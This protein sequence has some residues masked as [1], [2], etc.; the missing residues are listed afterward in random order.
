[1]KF[2]HTIKKSIYDVDFYNTAKMERNGVAMKYYTLF[3]MLMVCITMIPLALNFRVSLHSY[4]QGIDNIRS[5]IVDIYPDELVLNFKNG[6]VSSNV[7]EP[8]HIPIP[9]ALNAK[10]PKNLIT[11]NTRESITST[12]FDRYD[13]AA[14]LGHDA[15]WIYN[16]QENK[17]EI[18]KFDSFSKESIIINKQK[19]TEW[20][21]L[22]L[23]IGKKIIFL[24]IILLPFILF[25]F[26]WVKY[27]V[28][29]LF[30]AIVILLIAKARKT[31]LTYGQAY[32]I[33]LYLITLPILYST[34][35]MGP[36]TILDVP[37]GFTLLLI[38]VA[39]INLV[40]TESD[41][42]TPGATEQTKIASIVPM[43]NVQIIEN[44]TEAPKD[45][46]VEEKPTDEEKP[47][48]DT[49]ASGK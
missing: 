12:D 40:P 29:L 44:T 32:K 4:P 28:Y 7:E 30:G 6:K 35:T 17:I 36:L 14:I 38:M 19:A 25:A 10:N 24:V 8:Y 46:E 49:E 41:K 2:L 42:E 34:L 27:I 33:G 21:D 18:Q 43:P 13:T 9:G 26:I 48:R 16:S 45:A 39:F 23:N 22:I 37:F 5:Q 3:I 20:I 47:A 11:I 15:I 1:M 31:N